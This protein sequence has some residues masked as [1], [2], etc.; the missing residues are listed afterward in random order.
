MDKH[1]MT[2]EERVKQVEKENAELKQQL[3]VQH[4]MTTYQQIGK[5]MIYLSVAIHEI[6]IDFQKHEVSEKEN[7]KKEFHDYFEVIGLLIAILLSE[8]MD[9]KT[10]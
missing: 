2:L 3:G 1:E 9:K 6:P 8:K 7:L 4:E 5:F 10:Y